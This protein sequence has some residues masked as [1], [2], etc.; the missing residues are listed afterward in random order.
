MQPDPKMSG[1]TD[2]GGD[3]GG[4][5]YDMKIG[6]YIMRGKAGMMRKVL[7]DSEEIEGDD[8]VDST[9]YMEYR[10]VHTPC[11]ALGLDLGP[12]APHG[13]AREHG[14]ARGAHA[15]TVGEEG[16]PNPNPNPDPDPDP[17]PDPKQVQAN[18]MDE[19]DEDA[20]SQHT[21]LVLCPSTFAPG[22]KARALNSN[23]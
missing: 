13:R 1:A 20:L 2:R 3:E 22:K 8:V 16:D 15:R 7:Y 11:R 14:V 17:D 18:T 21:P 5:K 19:E 6:M 10:E 12:H 4:P 23:E 9:P